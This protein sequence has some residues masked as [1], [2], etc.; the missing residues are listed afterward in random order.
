V[1]VSKIANTTEVGAKYDAGRHPGFFFGDI[2]AARVRWKK[3]LGSRTGVLILK[4][5]IGY[6]FPWPNRPFGVCV[7]KVKLALFSFSKVDA[8]ADSLAHRIVTRYP[9]VIANAPEQTVSQRRVEE[10]IEDILSREVQSGSRLGIL[11]RTK[12]GHAFK[13]KLREIGYD[14]K[15]VDFVAKKLRAQLTRPT[16]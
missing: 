8:F 7:G 9:P 6:L 1:G 5:P 16:E 11:S 13:W 3:K 10:I 14:D 4:P 12:L 15:F 2:N